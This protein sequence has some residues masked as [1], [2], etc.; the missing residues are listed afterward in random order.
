MF[1]SMISMILP[2][3][4]KYM[5]SQPNETISISLDTANK[6]L[7]EKLKIKKL[8]NVKVDITFDVEKSTIV[9]SK[10]HID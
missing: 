2:K 10:K 9:I 7:S 5:A 8:K 1:E 3:A 4:I 6:W